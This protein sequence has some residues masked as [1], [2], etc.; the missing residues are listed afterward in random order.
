MTDKVQKL[1]ESKPSKKVIFD[2]VTITTEEVRKMLKRAKELE[3]RQ[4]T[5]N[6]KLYFMDYLTR[7][8]PFTFTEEEQKKYTES[9]SKVYKKT[10]SKLFESE[11]E[12]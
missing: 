2:S 11:V 7:V 5:E 3:E 8:T 12:K 9:I 1:L 10:G 4:K 6:R